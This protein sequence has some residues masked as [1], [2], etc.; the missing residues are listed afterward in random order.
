MIG[1]IY[2]GIAD[3]LMNGLD[4]AVRHVDLWNEQVAFIEEEAPFDFP[5][6]FVQFGQIDWKPVNVGTGL[7]WR[8]ECLVSLHIVSRW[9][10]S[11]AAGSG[12]MDEALGVFDLAKRIHYKLEDIP[13][14]GYDG[15]RLVGSIVNHNH[16]DIIENIEVYK[17][18]LYR[19]L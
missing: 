18:K 2:K 1:E 13:G 12:E 3:I 17:T 6:V 11:A 19:M 5:A 10:G 8:G 14:A 7:C 15:M 16:E 4:G 9:P